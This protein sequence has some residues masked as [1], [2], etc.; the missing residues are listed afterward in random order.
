MNIPKNRVIK[1]VIDKKAYKLYFS[2]NI[3]MADKF[4]R[5]RWDGSVAQMEVTREKY[6]Q[7]FNPNPKRRDSMEGVDV[8]G[9][10]Y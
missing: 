6:I 5:S 4:K 8:S 2:A 9:E 10:Q 3:I 1:F 7:Q